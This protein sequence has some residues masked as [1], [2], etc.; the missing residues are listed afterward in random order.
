[1]HQIRANAHTTPAVRAEIACSPEPSGTLARRYGV[2]AEIIRN[3]RERGP[4]D[5]LDRSARPHKLPWKA[6]DEDRAVVGA[7]RRATN[8]AVEDLTFVVAHFLPHLNRESVWRILVAKGLSRRR[9]STPERPVRGT[10]QFRDYDTKEVFTAR[11]SETFG[12][13]VMDLPRFIDE[14]YNGKRP[15]L[16]LGYPSPVQLEAMHTRP[17]V[18]AAA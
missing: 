6:S 8:F 4:A 17:P 13:I 12:E 3:W 2:S 11:L 9:P 18:K 16:A 15:D 1:M 14:V 7:L 10:G 5:C